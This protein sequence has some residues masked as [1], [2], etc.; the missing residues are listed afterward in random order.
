M[1]DLREQA[2]QNKNYRLYYALD[3]V[4]RYGTDLFNDV[5]DGRDMSLRLPD[6]L[7]KWSEDLAKTGQQ[8]PTFAYL[9]GDD[10]QRIELPPANQPMTLP[11]GGDQRWDH[12][13][14]TYVTPGNSLQFDVSA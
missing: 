5:G 7:Q 9:I 8:L 1:A 10:G 14:T 6:I 3:Y 13:R 4:M 2:F 12:I 11:D